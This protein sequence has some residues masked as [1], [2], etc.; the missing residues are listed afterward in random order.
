LR[1]RGGAREAAAEFKVVMQL[2]S[3]G[4]DFHDRKGRRRA[5]ASGLSDGRVCK[6][7]C[8][9]HKQSRRYAM[10]LRERLSARSGRLKTA[11]I[12]SPVR[13]RCGFFEASCHLLLFIKK[14][15]VMSP[16]CRE[17]MSQFT[18]MNSLPRAFSLHFSAEP[19]AKRCAQIRPRASD[20]ARAANQRLDRLR[21]A[22]LSTA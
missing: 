1:A 4:A 5:A 11:D 3:C 17:H 10:H 2:K 6:N 21:F 12:V 16:A 13:R 9:P 22:Q 18:A 7:S 15:T 20:S 19:A 8:K 14:M